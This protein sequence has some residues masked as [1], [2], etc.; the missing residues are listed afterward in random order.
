MAVAFCAAAAVPAAD[1]RRLDEDDAW[2]ACFCVPEDV[3]EPCVVTEPIWFGADATETD[4]AVL[5]ECDT[6]ERLPIASVPRTAIP[7]KPPV[8]VVTRTASERR[9]CERR[10]RRALAPAAAGAPKAGG[11]GS[12]SAK[13][14][15]RGAACAPTRARG[16]PPPGPPDAWP[17]H[18]E[19]PPTAGRTRTSG[20]VACA[21][22][23]IIDSTVVPQPGQDTTPLSCL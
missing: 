3:F 13:I 16:R 4:P 17:V 15:D 7:A 19:A 21:A 10:T 20:V 8:A 5:L 23:A 1:A 6:V 18:G 22:A 11:S 2:A 9:R 12:G 14:A